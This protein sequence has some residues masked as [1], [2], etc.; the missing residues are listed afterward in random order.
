MSDCGWCGLPLAD[1]FGTS[2][3][4]WGVEVCEYCIELAEMCWEPAATL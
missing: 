1:Q 2:K 3:V 4:V